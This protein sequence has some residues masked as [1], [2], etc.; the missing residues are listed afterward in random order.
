MQRSK[1]PINESPGYDIKPSDVEARAL[2]IKGMWSIPLLSLLP[3][4]LL[5]GVVA[6][7]KT[8]SKYNKLCE[9]K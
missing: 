4:Q 5:T 8:L 7:D 9:D 3:S 2:E 6:P 1:T